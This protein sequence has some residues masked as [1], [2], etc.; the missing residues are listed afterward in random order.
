VAASLVASKKF[1]LAFPI[2]AVKSNFVGAVITVEVGLKSG[3]A[4]PFFFLGVFPGFIDFPNEA[5]VHQQHL[6][7]FPI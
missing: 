3:D 7:V 2:A 5:R 6:R 4:N 1:A